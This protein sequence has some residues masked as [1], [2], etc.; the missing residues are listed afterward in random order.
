MKTT[1]KRVDIV[2]IP[3][4]AAHDVSSLVERS[5]AVEAQR[6]VDALNEAKEK[7][8]KQQKQKE[9]RETKKRQREQERE[10]KEEEE[11]KRRKEKSEEKARA[12]AAKKQA[13]EEECTKA[14]AAKTCRECEDKTYKANSNGWEVC[15]CGQYKVCRD[16]WVG[17]GAKERLREHMLSPN[18][19]GILAQTAATLQNRGEHDEDDALVSEHDD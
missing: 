3:G 13:K 12:A 1:T 9:E 7:E 19:T 17:K 15:G 4:E 14:K 11:A 8:A 18:C 16:C 10:E 2:H 6:K 5:D